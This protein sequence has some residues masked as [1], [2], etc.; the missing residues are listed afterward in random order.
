MIIFSI[1]KLNQLFENG[2]EVLHL[3][4]PTFTIDGYRELLRSVDE[5]YYQRIVIHQFHDLCKEFKL[6]GIHIQEQPRIDL[7]DQLFL[8]QFQERIP[9]F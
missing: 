8:P 4:K 3:R 6:K 9:V 1:C 2:L 7:G 5:Q